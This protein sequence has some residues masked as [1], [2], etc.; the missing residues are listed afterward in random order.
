MRTLRL[1]ILLTVAQ[2][3]L[4]AHEAKKFKKKKRSFRF[5][6]K[7][8]CACSGPMW[9]LSAQWLFIN[10]VKATC[11]GC[12]QAGTNGW[13]HRE[14]VQCYLLSVGLTLGEATNHWR[15]KSY[16]LSWRLSHGCCTGIFMYLGHS[17]GSGRLTRI[18]EVI[19][20]FKIL[21]IPLSRLFR[22]SATKTLPISF[23]II[24][25]FFLFWLT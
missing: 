4:G 1:L 15:Y 22:Y 18:N 14:F 13:G 10:A 8:Y 9:D 11:S 23:F 24:I 2:W 7:P 16:K 3:R 20:F 5:R 12:P 17:Q 6:L 21:F 19:S 25:F